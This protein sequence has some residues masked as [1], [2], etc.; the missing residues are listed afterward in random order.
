MMEAG[1]VE[2]LAVAKLLSSLVQGSDAY[3]NPPPPS[4]FDGKRP[5]SI[6]LPAYMQRFDYFVVFSF[7]FTLLNFFFF[8]LEW[9]SIQT[10]RGRL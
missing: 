9:C 10:A 1:Q 2:A 4:R 7:L 5:P 6:L 8:V 3:G